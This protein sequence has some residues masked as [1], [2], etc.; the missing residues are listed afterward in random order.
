MFPF[1]YT[2]SMFISSKNIFSLLIIT[3]GLIGSSNLGLAQDLDI[4]GTPLAIVDSELWYWDSSAIYTYDIIENKKELIRSD[5][6]ITLSSLYACSNSHAY[7][8]LYTG[9][10][11][12][13]HKVYWE[14]PIRFEKV[15]RIYSGDV[16]TFKCSLDK[17]FTKLADQ[18]AQ[19][20]AL[21]FRGYLKTPVRS[22]NWG[23]ENYFFS[24][25]I[26]KF[27]KA[28][29]YWPLKAMWLD[30]NGALISTKTIPAGPWV[31]RH[32]FIDTIRNFSCGT[33]CYTRFSAFSVNDDYYAV[34][35][36][37]AVPKKGRG[38]FKLVGDTWRVIKKGN[39]S[40]IL[41]VSDYGQ[42]LAIADT[43]N[44]NKIDIIQLNNR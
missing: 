9:E 32:N 37:S 27:D 7:M 22:K 14:K 21:R 19:K 20:E 5:V 18:L 8:T 34:A 29:R 6:N 35:Y 10:V 12:G 36:G 3:F 24:E 30:E 17:T 28:A 1:T 41:I 39:F 4:K 13:S 44:G 2:K 31:W 43:S 16:E 40:R 26:N 25:T 33:D 42:F 11:S 23:N 15:D 38:V